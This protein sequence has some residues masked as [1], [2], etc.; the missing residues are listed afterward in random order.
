VTR[1]STKCVVFLSIELDP[2]MLTCTQ[3][4][5]GVVGFIRSTLGFE[6]EIMRQG[7]AETFH[8]CLS[9]VQ[10]LNIGF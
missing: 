6:Q 4:G 8:Y 1:L 10:Y 7:K 3:T 2:Y 9:I 5:K